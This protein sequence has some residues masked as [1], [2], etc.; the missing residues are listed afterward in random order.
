MSTPDR[1]P[2]KRA[3][4]GDSPHEADRDPEVWLSDG[5]I[6]V[7]SRN[8][9]FRV[10]KSVLSHHS[11]VFRDLFSL[12]DQG[13]DEMMDGCPVD[14]QRLFLVLCCG[15]NYYYKNDEILPVPVGVLA[16]LIRMGHKYA[17]PSILEHALARLKKYYTTDLKAWS[18]SA[19][20][21]RYV[22]ASPLDAMTVIQLAH[23]TE[24]SS[25]LPTAYLICCSLTRTSYSP[26]STKAGQL[27]LCDL[28]PSDL[29]AVINGNADLIKTAANR[30]FGFASV[31]P[32][33]RCTTVKHCMYAC[34]A[35]VRHQYTEQNAL[36]FTWSTTI[37]SMSGAFLQPVAQPCSA[38]QAAV[39]DEDDRHRKTTWVLLPVMFGIRPQPA[40]WPRLI[41]S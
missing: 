30:V 3:R 5:N 2:T 21:A 11:D 22:L 18:D 39:V 33:K 13:V 9:A 1:R 12:P 34:Q 8:V 15:K 17:I 41:L 24:T 7:V 37:G 28:P 10:H 40:G 36:T 26:P 32:S 35:L 29:A 20:R 38:C 27:V 25:L 14:L 19:E 23:L 4:I 16:S 31:I 6:V